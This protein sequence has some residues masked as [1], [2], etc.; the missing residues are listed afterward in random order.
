MSKILIGGAG[1]APTENVIK[2]IIDEEE[3]VGIGSEP[4]D[5]MLS[6]AHKKYQ[7][8]YAIDKTYKKRLLEI[9]SV[10]K[11]VVNVVKCLVRYGLIPEIRSFQMKNLM[12]I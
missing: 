12:K 3:I 8:P 10:C 2:S 1:G 6:M 4:Y 9:I 7:V 11:I 5:M